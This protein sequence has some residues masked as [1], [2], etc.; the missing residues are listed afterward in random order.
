MVNT[1]AKTGWTL[2]ASRVRLP[3]RTLRSHPEWEVPQHS[4]PVL[5]WP[6]GVH[7]GLCPQLRRKDQIARPKKH[8]K[9]R[10]PHQKLVSASECL[11]LNYILSLVSFL[12]LCLVQ[13]ILRQA[14]KV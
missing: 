8:G 3:D 10:K 5:P 6:A 1:V 4:P 14:V 13:V 11:H 12:H 7:A 2:P 9:Q